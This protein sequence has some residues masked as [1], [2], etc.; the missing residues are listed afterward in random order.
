MCRIE[1]R[2]DAALYKNILADELVRIIRWHHLNKYEI[3]YQH[4]NDPKHTANI[5]LGWL[6]ANGIDTLKFPPQSP[7]LNPIEHLWRKLHVCVRER[8]EEITD[9]TTLWEVLQQEWESIAVS[10]WRK[11]VHTMPERL[12]A[13]I[14]V[15]G[16][17]TY[18]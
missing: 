14:R 18:W 12:A 10:E 17:H 7:D 9:R 16:G 11:L 6:E 13:V 4:D 2:M 15:K 5:T 8:Q 1:G 3:I